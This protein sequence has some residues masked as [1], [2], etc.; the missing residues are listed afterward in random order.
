MVFTLLQEK[1]VEQNKPLY[2]MF[3]NLTKAFDTVS[4]SGLYKILEKIRYPLKLLQMINAFQAGMTAAVIFDGDI[5]EPF[6]LRCGIKQWSVMSPTL[7]SI[8]QSNLLGHAFPSPDGIAHHARHYGNLFNLAH[9]W[10]K[11]KANTVLICDLIFANNVAFCTH[12]V[13][14]FQEVCTAFSASR[15]L[16][17]LKQ[18]QRRWLCLLQIYHHAAFK[19]MVSCSWQSTSSAP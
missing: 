3:I 19:S 18:A 7:L 15:N 17:G 2:V 8:Y 13:P 12:S 10:A 11:T 16:F 4:R 5:S 9:L 1:C 14:K 6:N